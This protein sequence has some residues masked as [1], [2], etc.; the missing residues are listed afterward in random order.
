MNVQSLSELALAK[1]TLVILIYIEVIVL[2]WDSF[3]DIVITSVLP[4]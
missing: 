4:R 3:S 2:P 1:Y